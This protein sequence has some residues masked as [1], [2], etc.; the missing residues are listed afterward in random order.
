MT[1]KQPISLF[2]LKQRWALFGH[3]LR[4]HP[5]TPANQ[6]MAYYFE[7][8]GAKRFRGRPRTTLATVIDRDLKC[9]AAAQPQFAPQLRKFDS[10]SDLFIARM[11]AADRRLWKEMSNNI[12]QAAEDNMPIY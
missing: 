6:A 3:I 4:S 8:T 7:S 9:L 5:M 12:L 10:T 1:G 11:M 2:V